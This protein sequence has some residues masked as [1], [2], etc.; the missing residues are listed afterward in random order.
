VTTARPQRA[1]GHPRGNLPLTPPRGHRLG[2]RPHPP[3]RAGPRTLPQQASLT[4]DQVA[5][6]VGTIDPKTAVTDER[7]YLRAFF[8]KYLRHDDNHLLDGPSP[9]FPDIQFEP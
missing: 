5:A 7:A 3:G 1:R 9:R 2:Q 8:D 4:P 6:I